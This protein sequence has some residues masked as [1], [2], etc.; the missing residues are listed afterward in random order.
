MPFLDE[1]VQLLAYM[2]EWVS[3]AGAEA[4]RI[5]HALGV[6]L[7]DVEHIGSTAVPGLEAKPSIDLMLGVPD[8]PAPSVRSALQ[9]LGYECLGEAGVSGREYY[10][11]RR[12][13]SFNLH[14]VLKGGAHWKNNLALRGYLRESAAAR[15]QYAEA[16]RAALAAGAT[17]LVSYSTAKAAVVATLLHK[18]VCGDDGG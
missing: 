16:K 1:P 6:A 13:A 5:A 7:T 10:R 15:Q 9:A 14:V 18:A 11:F 4:S 12:A 17:T 8:Y 3:Q 2:P